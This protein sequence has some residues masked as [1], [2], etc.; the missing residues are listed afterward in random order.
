M[1]VAAL[2]NERI[3]PMSWLIASGAVCFGY[4][5][6]AFF[7]NQHRTRSQDVAWQRRQRAWRNAQEHLNTARNASGS[8][9]IKHTRDAI[10]ELIADMLNV[11][12]AGMTAHEASLALSAAKV[13]GELRVQTVSLLE[14]LEALEYGSPAAANK[15]TLV[16]SA[17]KLLPELQRQLEPQR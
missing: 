17:E 5:A 11:G 4:V 7:L 1:D 14:S 8:D 9:A 3:N 12:A 16:D 6:F 13:S 2:G 10:V 15:K